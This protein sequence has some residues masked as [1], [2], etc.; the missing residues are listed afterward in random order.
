MVT[1]AQKTPNRIMY[2]LWNNACS[3]A[4]CRLQVESMMMP[5]AYK[6]D[7]SNTKALFEFSFSGGTHDG[8]I[9]SREDAGATTSTL[10]N[11]YLVLETTERANPVSK[12][13]RYKIGHIHNT[14]S[15]GVAYQRYFLPKAFQ[16]IGP[17]CNMS[18][19]FRTLNSSRID[20]GMICE[21]GADVLNGDTYHKVNYYRMYHYA[22]F[23]TQNTLDGFDILELD[24]TNPSSSGWTPEIFMTS[25]SE[26]DTATGNPDLTT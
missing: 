7:G 17:F 16:E 12:R 22:H 1:C 6:V 18:F 4:Y 23:S 8:E 3:G 13:V 9:Y 15:D 21:L 11:T 10:V 5:L 25:Y 24:I 14:F 26:Y 2:K 20:E 19:G